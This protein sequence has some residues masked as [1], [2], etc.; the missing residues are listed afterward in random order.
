MLCLIVSSE[1]WF[2]NWSTFSHLS[3]KNAKYCLITEM[4]RLSFFSP[5]I[6]IK[7]IL[8]FLFFFGC[9][10][11]ILV[12]PG[13]S[14]F[15]ARR[16]ESQQISKMSQFSTFTAK[17]S[18]FFTTHVRNLSWTYTYYTKCSAFS[19]GSVGAMVQN[20]LSSTLDAGD[21]MFNTDSASRSQQKLYGCLHSHIFKQTCY[22]CSTSKLFSVFSH[23]DWNS[24]KKCI[25]V[26]LRFCALTDTLCFV[27]KVPDNLYIC[28]IMTM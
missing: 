3:S 2:D 11:K 4:T 1:N 28:D 9:G 6:I 27:Q 23:Q 16:P 24:W 25:A 17:L 22:T 19:G 13:L 14:Q 15:Q 20:N 26:G 18:T 10:S 5:N 8:C 7:L 21:V 12:C